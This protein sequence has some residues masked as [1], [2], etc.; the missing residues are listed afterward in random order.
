MT[1]T[2]SERAYKPRTIRYYGGKAKLTEFIVSGMMKS[3]LKKG[4]AVLDGFT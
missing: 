3:G 4:M 1:I 2:N